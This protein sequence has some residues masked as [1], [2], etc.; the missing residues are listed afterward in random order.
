[1]SDRTPVLFAKGAL[2]GYCPKCGAP[3]IRR[4]N[5]KDTCQRGHSYPS[6]E[7]LECAKKQ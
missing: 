7:A 6:V 4:A 1:M 2:Y 3:G 5:D